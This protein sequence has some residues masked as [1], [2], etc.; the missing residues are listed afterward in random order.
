M[1]KTIMMLGTLGVL[2]LSC[3][4]EVGPQGIQGVTGATGAIGS[5]GSTGA[6]GNAN[7]MNKT[8]TVYSSDWQWDP[9]YNQ[10]YYNYTTNLDYQSGVICYVLSGNGQEAM[11]YHSQIN[12]TI[13][14]FAN[15]LLTSGYL[16]FEY[17]N[18]SSTLARPSSDTYFYIVSIPPG[19]IINPN[20]DLKNYEEVKKALE[21]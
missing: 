4:K 2:I 21:F 8:V 16:K 1:R 15:R 12:G 7:V 3:K 18:K 11:P 17:Y 9:S 19:M 13:T 20:V 6:Q 10:W 14:S 5:T